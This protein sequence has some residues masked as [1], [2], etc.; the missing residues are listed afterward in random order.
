MGP[1]YLE[2]KENA[3]KS[4]NKGVGGLIWKANTNGNGRRESSR[5]DEK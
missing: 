3:I 1:T 4:R 2:S 5:L